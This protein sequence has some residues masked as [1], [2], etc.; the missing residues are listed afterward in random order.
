MPAFE[1]AVQIKR[2][3][4]QQY[5]KIVDVHFVKLINFHSVKVVDRVR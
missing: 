2:D 3:T 5:F 4:N 1:H